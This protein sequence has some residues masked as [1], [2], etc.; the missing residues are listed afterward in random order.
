MLTPG[1]ALKNAETRAATFGFMAFLLNQTPDDDLILG[2]RT[3]D[4]NTFIDSIPDHD[5]SQDIKHGLTE[6]FKFTQ[7]TSKIPSNDAALMLAK[8]WTCL[9][10]GVSPGYGPAP[11][12]EGLYMSGDELGL[13]I[14][15]TVNHWYLENGVRVD[16]DHP[17]RPDYL[18]LELDFIR[19]L[20]E[21]EARAWAEGNETEATKHF[22]RN[23]LFIAEHIAPWVSRFCEE[24]MGFA[25]TGFYRGLIKIIQGAIADYTEHGR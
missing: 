23:T 15:Q 4:F 19:H 18:G 10:R 11:P 5:P 3:T 7:E 9:F 20:S 21:I 8:D 24:A 2:L 12:Y 13:D 17:D 16:S 14:I 25:K 1:E 6:L 22:Q